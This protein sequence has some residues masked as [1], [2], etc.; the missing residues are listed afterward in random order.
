MILTIHALK[1]IL[2]PFKRYTESMNVY[3]KIEYKGI[4]YSISEILRKIC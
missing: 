4:E 1:I 3:R 2:H